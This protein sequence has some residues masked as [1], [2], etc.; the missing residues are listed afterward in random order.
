M[1]KIGIFYGSSTGA[2]EEVATKI[3]EALAIDSSDVKNISDASVA[4][5]ADYDV[6]LLGS[7]TWGDGDLQDDWMDV[8]DDLKSVDL[9]G[10]VVGLFGLG[11]AGS[12]GDSFCGGM[13]QLYNLLS[14]S[15]AEFVGATD[16]D[17]YDF[18]DS[19]SLIDGKFVGLPLDEANEYDLTDER[20][21]AWLERI[22]PAFN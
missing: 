17:G 11:D 16:P 7:S 22:K 21:A 5:F 1:K 12:F 15:K 18:G 9:S 19:P 3:G 2:T 6:L 20:I 10:K 14:D 4:D 13:G 8:E